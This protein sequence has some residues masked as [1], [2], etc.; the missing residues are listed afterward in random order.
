MCDGHMTDKIKEA[1]IEKALFELLD[2]NGDGPSIESFTRS[3][4]AYEAAMWRPISETDVSVGKWVIDETRDPYLCRPLPTP[5]P[6][7]KKT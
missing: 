7:E 2:S 4:Q 1:A 6:P 5:P 3:I